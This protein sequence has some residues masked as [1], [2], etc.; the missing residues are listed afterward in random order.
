MFHGA[1]SFIAQRGQHSWD[2]V[3]SGVPLDVLKEKANSV[4]MDPEIMQ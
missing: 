2:K 1:V 4:D 3:F